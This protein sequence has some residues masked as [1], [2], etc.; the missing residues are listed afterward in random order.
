[1]LNYLFG[2]VGFMPH[3]YCLLWRPDIVAMHVASDVMIFAAYISIAL[4][5]NR[6]IKERPE[7]RYSRV[8]FL[9]AAF[10]GGCGVTHLFGAVS[11]WWPAYGAEAILKLIVAGISVI[12]A[13]EFWRLLPTLTQYPSFDEIEARRIA[14]AKLKRNETELKR[15]LD[16]ALT[17][18][19]TKAAF[20]AAMSHDLRTPLNAILGFGEV[21]SMKVF[22]AMANAKQSEYVEHIRESAAQ[23]L[24]LI[25]D[26]L[27]LSGVEADTKKRNIRE[28]DA[29]QMLAAVAEQFEV[30]EGFKRRHIAVNVT[31]DP[32]KIVADEHCLRR[33]LNNLLSNSSKY[34]P[35]SSSIDIEA[36]KL[37]GGTE[38]SVTDDGPGF[39]RGREEEMRNPFQRETAS[40]DGLGIGLAIVDALVRQHGWT[41]SLANTRNRGARVSIWMPDPDAQPAPQ[42]AQKSKGRNQSRVDMK[43]AIAAG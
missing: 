19:K 26:L 23:L 39:P 21:L 30:S 15:A 25:N 32:A 20:L 14:E 3:G 36:R 13:W 34:A 11:L 28:L 5:L 9:T 8:T 1:M 18:E 42:P 22:G 27:E 35:N 10:I 38:L 41:M 29:P 24:A 6:F 37:P 12:A 40:D 43:S 16:Q 31:A 2:T 4:C 17:A 33:I 7:F